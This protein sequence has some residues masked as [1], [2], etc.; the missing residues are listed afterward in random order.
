MA[1]W[2]RHGARQL[3]RT[4][5]RIRLL[6]AVLA[7]ALVVLGLVT[8]AVMRER[9]DASQQVERRAA[10]ALL[11][12]ADLYVA[13]AD[14]DTTAS[15]GFLEQGLERMASPPA[16]RRR[17]ATGGVAAHRGVGVVTPAPSRRRGREHAGCW[18]A[19]VQRS[20]RVGPGRTTTRAS[21]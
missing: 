2:L 13:L 6:G 10:P 16:V 9:F 15:R 20:R 19:R 18:A 21:C 11:A 1:S 12:A 8:G 17:T 4:P 7:V 5:G 14:A 3:S